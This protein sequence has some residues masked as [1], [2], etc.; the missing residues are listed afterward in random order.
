MSFETLDLLKRKDSFVLCNRSIDGLIT[1]F[2][3]TNNHYGAY[4][5][6]KHLIEEGCRQLS[7]FSQRKYSTAISRY[8]GFKTALLDC[9]EEVEEGPVLLG[10]YEERIKRKAAENFFSGKDS[11]WGSLF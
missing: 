2:V 3:G 5:A 8:N 4:M 9:Q 6:T 7:Y 10:N 11:G 1:P